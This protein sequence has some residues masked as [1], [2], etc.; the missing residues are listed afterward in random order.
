MACAMPPPRP[1]PNSFYGALFITGWAGGA[2]VGPDLVPGGDGPWGPADPQGSGASAT[3]SQVR[4]GDGPS[5]GFLKDRPRI[6]LLRAS[7][8]PPESPRSALLAAQLPGC[9]I[10]GH[11]AKSFRAAG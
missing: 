10:V 3:L 5:P 1:G 11:P 6:G 4:F 8:R 7:E 9:L 2:Q